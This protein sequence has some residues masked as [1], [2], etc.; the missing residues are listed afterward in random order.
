[1]ADLSKTACSQEAKLP[2]L[3]AEDAII[4]P[5]S[6]DRIFKVLL[7]HPDAKQVLMDII[8]AV[9][10]KKVT[11]ATIRN[12]ELPVSNIDEKEQRFDVNC[13]IENG[14]QIDV[15]MHSTPVYETGMERK[16]F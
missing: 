6:D 5:P 12:V 3:L 11:N 10:R 13:T 8:S 1:M 9:I 15:E 4:L 16:N 2:Q 7:T 14:D